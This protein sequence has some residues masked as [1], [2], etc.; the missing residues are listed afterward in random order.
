M[1]D[2]SALWGF[3]LHQAWQVLWG[4]FFAIVAFQIL[5]HRKLLQEHV[6]PMLDELRASMLKAL[7]KYIR[8]KKTESL[9]MAD[10]I[11]VAAA[12]IGGAFLTAMTLYAMVTL[13]ANL[14]TP[15]G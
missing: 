11:I 15:V 5:R 7:N 10:S 14:S 6:L 3:T 1:E 12:M 8:L 2:M 9:S 4:F 13:V